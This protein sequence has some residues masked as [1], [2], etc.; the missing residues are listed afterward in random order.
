MPYSGP[1]WDFNFV[2]NLAKLQLASWATKWLY[3]LDVT[4]HLPPT[5][6]PPKVKSDQVRPTQVQSGGV[7][8]GQ[9]KSGQVLLKQ[10]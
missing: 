6:Q 1:T 10:E 7:K 4:T 8:S 9:G 5:H 3:Y 2:C